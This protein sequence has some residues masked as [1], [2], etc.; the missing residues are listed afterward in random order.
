MRKYMLRFAIAV[1]A[2]GIG[3]S[4][5]YFP[6]HIQLKESV[7][8]AVSRAFADDGPYSVLDGNKIR[9]KP[10]DATFEVPKEWLNS[11]YGKTLFLD[12]QELKY[13]N[14][15]RRFEGE[16]SRVINS[17]LD[18]NDCAA[19][20]GEMA[21]DSG[22]VSDQA[23]IYVVNVIPDEIQRLVVEKGLTTAQLVFDEA[24][25]SSGNVGAWHKSTI[26]YYQ[27]GSHT[28]LFR[29]IDFYSRSFGTK[30]VVF[31]FI[32]SVGGDQYVHPMLNSF[33]WNNP[34]NA[35]SL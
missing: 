1:F 35:P 5:I 25:V 9:V 11:Q 10:F 8:P 24:K 23:R 6:L 33:T 4:A 29:E 15:S 31:L 17:V 2:F 18:F 20:A 21:W 26:H 32:H 22:S 14:L 16:E 3:I 27:S 30:T 12:R 7:V 13:V 28:F 19:H 34:S